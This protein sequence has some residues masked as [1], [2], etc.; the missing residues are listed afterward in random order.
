VPSGCGNALAS[1]PIMTVLFAVVFGGF[2]RP[3]FGAL[4]QRC[5]ARRRSRLLDRDVF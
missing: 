5:G 3:L 4:A 1:P 2:G